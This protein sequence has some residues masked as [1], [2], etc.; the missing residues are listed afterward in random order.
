M[1]TNQST[2]NFGGTSYPNSQQFTTSLL[3]NV[4]VKPE[5]DDVCEAPIQRT[6]FEDPTA[7]SFLSSR[8]WNEAPSSLPEESLTTQESDPSTFS[9]TT[10]SS[11]GYKWRKYGQKFGRRNILGL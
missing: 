10:T 4:Q 1:G 3:P 6:E 5:S 8:N 7:G 9:S 2:Q 11:D